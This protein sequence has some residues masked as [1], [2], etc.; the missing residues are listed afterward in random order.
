[1]L[2]LSKK[3]KPE[4]G[5]GLFILFVFV[6]ML[7]QASFAFKIHGDV[8]PARLTE[9][10]KDEAASPELIGKIDSVLSGKPETSEKKISAEYLT[11]QIY[12]TKKV[13][14]VPAMAGAKNSFAGNGGHY[15][16]YQI[17]QGDTLEKISRE[18]YGNNKMVSALIRINRLTDMKKLRDGNTLRV[19]K[20]GLLASVK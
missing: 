17:K 18:L 12:A 10:A 11:R 3:A 19:P 14:A 9:T 15:L 5:G 16:E 2:T 13:E 4:F 6:L 1:M 20:I 8:G 7:L